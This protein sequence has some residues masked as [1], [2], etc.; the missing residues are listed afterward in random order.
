MPGRRALL[1]VLGLPDPGT[2]YLEAYGV[3]ASRAPDGWAIPV[4]GHWALL[5]FPQDF[6]AV[7]ACV[8]LATFAVDP[9]A[10]NRRSKLGRKSRFN[11]SHL[12]GAWLVLFMIFNVIW[13]MFLF[14]GAGRGHGQPALRQR[15]L[16]L[17]RPSATSS[18]G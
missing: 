17:A 11:G 12:G 6:I 10:N 13:T 2:V 5:G 1:R 9:A 8:G 3:A 15:R 7:M 16:R 14:R 18:T 4:V